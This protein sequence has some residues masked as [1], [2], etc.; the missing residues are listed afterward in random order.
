MLFCSSD[1]LLAVQQNILG[2]DTSALQPISVQ[3][4]PGGALRATLRALLKVSDITHIESSVPA[5]L[6]PY[7]GL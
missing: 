3:L 1:R 6:E 7:R 5:V 2:T 4:L